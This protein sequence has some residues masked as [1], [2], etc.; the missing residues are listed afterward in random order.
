MHVGAHQAVKK[1]AVT[2]D[3]VHGTGPSRTPVRVLIVDPDV[4]TR[5][6]V[7][8]ILAQ[9][10]DIAVVGE[11]SIGDDAVNKA[12][13]YQPDVVIMAIQLA[14]GMDGIMATRRITA[15]LA[16]GTKVLMLTS[17]DTEEYER[18]ARRAGAT[19]FIS[20]RSSEAEL[21][22]TV[23]AVAS[24]R[25]DVSSRRPPAA[26]GGRL[27]FT[28]QLTERE[29][30]VLNA[31][32]AGLTNTEAADHLCVSIDTLKTHLKHIYSKCGIPNRARL[33]VEARASGFGALLPACHL[34]GGGTGAP[35]EDEAGQDGESPQAG[36]SFCSGF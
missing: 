21:L 13:A 35:W 24:G 8:T 20:K 3:L 34:H 19:A 22:A 28:P 7:R 29:R 30:Q 17:F 9:A 18:Q 6:G 5:V 32:A 15:R 25:G 2:M 31:V 36:L 23:R 33:V 4:A 16:P 10:H 1:E 26:R 27:S 12:A 14:G 11:A